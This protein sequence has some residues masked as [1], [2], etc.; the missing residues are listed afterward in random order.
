[1]LGRLKRSLWELERRLLWYY[2]RALAHRIYYKRVTGKNLNLDQPR[3]LNEKIQWLMV[4]RY[5]KEEAQVADKLLVRDYVAK[6]G[7][8]NILP[9]LH[10]VYRS[11]S[12]I[13]RANLPSSFALKLNHG[14]GPHYYSLCP[15][16]EAYDFDAEF[17]RMDKGL[18]KDYARRSLEYHY[19]YIEPRLY[20]EEYLEGQDDNSPEDYKVF[21]FH[22]KANCILVTSARGGELKRDY[23]DLDWTY[24]DYTKEEYRSQKPQ[25]RPENF[26]QMLEIAEKLAQDFDFARVDFYNIQGRIIFG[27]ITL[28]PAGGANKTYKEEALAFLGSLLDLEVR[29]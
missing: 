26:E 19:S 3:D 13:D 24:L 5:G 18:K 7:Y 29:S 25:P 14:S 23:Y 17:A 27:E 12:E 2:P 20:V 21:C 10:G 8:E 9:R 16:K 1:M 11:S 15:S 6:K 22:G 28:T 4:Y